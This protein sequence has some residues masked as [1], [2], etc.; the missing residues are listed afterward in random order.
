LQPAGPP[1][2]ALL[3][4]NLISA[5][6]MFT[7]RV[8]VVLVAV[9]L[10]VC[11]GLGQIPTGKGLLPG[12]GLVALIIAGWLVFFG[13]HVARMDFRQDLPNADILKA[14]PLRGWQVVLGEVL[15]PLAVLTAVQWFL[16]TVALVL[17]APERHGPL[18]MAFSEKLG[19][20]LAA[21]LVLPALNLISLLI[22]NT[23]VLLFP[24]WLQSGRESPQGIEATGQR[25]LFAL[26]QFVVLGVALA[27]AAG[28]VAAV[29][30]VGRFALPLA[31]VL[32]LASAAGTL[33]LGLEAALGV[34]LMGRL[35]ER[36]DLSAEAN[37]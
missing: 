37:P 16:L 8:W 7:A 4:K 19:G 32:P 27:P 22:I 15:A 30:F 26:G 23:A 1:A 28:V 20:A 5:G 6:Q 24:A 31:L 35:F 36:F 13:P 3:W 29:L 21:A 18:G 25:L 2:V 12:V 11:L 10:G 33:V 9:G 17:L 34:M 14:W